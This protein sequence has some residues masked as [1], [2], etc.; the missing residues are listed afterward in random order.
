M[1][2]GQGW[3]DQREARTLLKLMPDLLKVCRLLETSYSPLVWEKG[4]LIHFSFN[5]TSDSRLRHSHPFPDP[6][7]KIYDLRTMRPLP[8]I[9]FSAG[10]AFIHSMPN[11][12]SSLAVISSTGLVNVVDAA[13]SSAANEFYQVGILYNY[14]LYVN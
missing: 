14:L 2:H 5:M 11:R 12:S 7:V 13:N 4:E 3:G 9:P 10:P 8:P 6:L 1:I